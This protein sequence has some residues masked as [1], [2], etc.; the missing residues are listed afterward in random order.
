[1]EL[2]FVPNRSIEIMKLELEEALACIEVLTSFSS[3]ENETNRI[4]RAE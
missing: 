1:M 4:F 2:E 3:R